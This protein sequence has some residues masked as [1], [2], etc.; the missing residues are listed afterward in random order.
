M[1]RQYYF[2][3]RVI[4][5]TAVA[6]ENNLDDNMVRP[7]RIYYYEEIAVED[8]TSDFTRALYGVQSGDDHHY[9]EEARSP[10]VARLYPWHPST[11]LRVLPGE[12]L[13]VKCSGVAA[14]DEL[15]LYVAGYFTREI[16]GPSSGVVPGEEVTL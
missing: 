4:I 3:D 5:S 15:I 10:V 1:P 8:R 14:G 6:G 11:P 7:G 16:S 2:R 9:Y 13:R 12:R